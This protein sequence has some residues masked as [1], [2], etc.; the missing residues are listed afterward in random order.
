MYQMINY[1]Q[2]NERG[3]VGSF[4]RG[5]LYW[6]CVHRP[7]LS[8]NI[9]R[10]TASGIKTINITRFDS[11]SEQDDPISETKAGEFWGL[12]NYKK[13]P[14]VV[15]SST[16]QEYPEQKIRGDELLVVAPLYSL[17]DKV[18]NEYKFGPQTVWDAI[19]YNIKSAFYLPRSTSGEVNE[20]LILFERIHSIHR[21]WLEP[22]FP[23]RLSSE[24][25]LY[26]DL[27][28]KNYLFGYIPTKIV[29]EIQA[30]RTLVGND[31]QIRIDV[32]GQGKYLRS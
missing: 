10:W 12:T 28:I 4:E 22:A 26:L 20:S 8:P 9:R 29:E 31:P 7:L 2:P 17:R 27:W 16:C 19:I 21:S 6:T 3:N 15:L 11:N 5:M 32:F 18:T 30:Y 24:A 14:V 25:M 23:V 13:R 1:Y